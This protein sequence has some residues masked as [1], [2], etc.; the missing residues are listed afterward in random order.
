ML[1]APPPRP[2]IDERMVF[3]MEKLRM[4]LVLAASLLGAGGVGAGAAAAH[5]TGAGVLDTA[6]LYALAHAAALAGI[7][8]ASPPSALILLPG[9][10]IALGALMF[11]VDLALRALAG[12]KLFAM[13]AP[14]GGVLLIA[15]WLAFGLGAA[16]YF[17]GKARQN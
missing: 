8:L 15:G 6:S 5:V 2:E 9:A 13:A 4:A 16:I 11:C 10:V 7:A 12:A 3:L 1:K 17:A 14:A